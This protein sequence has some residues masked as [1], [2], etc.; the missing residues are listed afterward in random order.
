MK[1]P[2]LPLILA[3]TLQL[4]AACSAND[5]RSGSSSGSDYGYL[6]LEGS[7]YNREAYLDGYQTGVDPDDDSRILRLRSGKHS[8]E[9]RSSNRILLQ[10]EVMI[11]AGQTVSITVP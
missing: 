8:L 4:M 11:E 7:M 2:Y 9:I 5:P 6:C 3:L 10:E 1:I